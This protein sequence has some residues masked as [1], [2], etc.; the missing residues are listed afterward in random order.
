[1]LIVTG[2]S[3]LLQIVNG[4]PLTGVD[5][6]ILLLVIGPAAAR[7]VHSLFEIIQRNRVRIGHQ[8]KV[9]RVITH[10]FGEFKSREIR[11]AGASGHGCDFDTQP[12]RRL[13][14]G[15][16]ALNIES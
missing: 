1:M 10:N 9:V 4:A 16:V 6:S 3:K 2:C 14:S 13:L 12:F 8:D 11:R 15:P 7:I 5:M